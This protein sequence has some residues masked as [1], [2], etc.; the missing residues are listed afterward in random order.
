MRLDRHYVLHACGE[1]I[2]AAGRRRIH[3]S[4]QLQAVR[5]LFAEQL[6]LTVCG[7]QLVDRI[8]YIPFL[9]TIFPPTIVSNTFVLPIVFFGTL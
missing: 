8:V 4:R 3:R 1:P 2:L 9:Q 6:G 5:L 7:L